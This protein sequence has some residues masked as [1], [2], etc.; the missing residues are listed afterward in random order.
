MVFSVISCQGNTPSSNQ[1]AESTVNVKVDIQTGKTISEIEQYGNLYVV[2]LSGNEKEFNFN[3]LIRVTKSN[4]TIVE[5]VKLTSDKTDIYVYL[6]AADED[7]SQQE[8]VKSA[9]HNQ[10]IT[11]ANVEV[12]IKTANGKTFNEKK[13]VTIYVEDVIFISKEGETPNEETKSR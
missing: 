5:P 11:T 2:I 1:P 8:E 12:T 3:N 7:A 9:N 6:I 13:E 4:S 10:N